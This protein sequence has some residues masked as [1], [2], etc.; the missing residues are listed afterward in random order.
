MG[1]TYLLA[2]NKYAAVGYL[3]DTGN[4]V[5]VL[6]HDTHRIVLDH[7]TFG[8][9][10]RRI[11]NMTDFFASNVSFRYTCTDGN[12]SLVSSNHFRRKQL[13]IRQNGGAA[14]IALNE[15]ETS[16]LIP[17]LHLLSRLFHQCVLLQLY[18]QRFLFDVLQTSAATNT[19]DDGNAGVLRF[20]LE[21]TFRAEGFPYNVLFIQLDHLKT[22]YPYLTRQLLRLLLTIF[23][24][25]P[26]P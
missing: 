9:L 2:A 3:P 22:T 1:H 19:E 20:V 5:V 23:N 4:A 26:L 7:G 25:K 24:T 14:T 13:R 11:T 6:D 17:I 8:E 15:A 18:V 21:P 12:T 10:Y 16:R